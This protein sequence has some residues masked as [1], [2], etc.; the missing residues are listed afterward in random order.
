M[1]FQL[2]LVFTLAVVNMVVALGV[3][4]SKHLTRQ[5]FSQYSEYR[6]AIDDLNMEWSRLQIEESAFSEHSLVE[7]I[8]QTRLNMVLPDPGTTVLIAR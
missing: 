2:S 3:V 7:D 4:Y 6:S 8:A 1:R 5:T